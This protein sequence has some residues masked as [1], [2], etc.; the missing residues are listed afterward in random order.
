MSTR[1]S[2]SGWWEWF[3][4]TPVWPDMDK[5]RKAFQID[6]ISLGFVI[7]NILYLVV[8]AIQNS[9]VVAEAFWPSA[10][11]FFGIALVIR[12]INHSG[13]VRA[14]SL[15]MLAIF[16][17][18]YN[19]SSLIT[20]GIFSADYAA[21]V[22]LVVVAGLLVSFR[23]AVLLALVSLGMGVYIVYASSH[24]A[25]SPRLATVTVESALA[26]YSVFFSLGIATL[27][28]ATRNLQAALVDARQSNRDLQA[29]RISLEDQ[30]TE[31]TR[32][33]E[34]ARQ[35][36]EVSR[37]EAE[38]ARQQ[39]EA[40]RAAVEAQAWRASGQVQLDEVLRGEQSPQ[41]L[42][43]NALRVLC[44]YLNLPSAL[45]YLADGEM[46]RRVGG[47]AIDAE[48]PDTFQLGEGLVGQAALDKRAILLDPVPA[49]VLR[50][51]SALGE[52]APSQVLI[53]PLLNGDALV[54]VLELA[55]LQ[56]LS[57]QERQFLQ[58]VEG[59]LAS[60]L[61]TAQARQRVNDLLMQTQRQAE[62]LQAQ[63]EELRA[64]NEELQAQAESVHGQMRA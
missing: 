6:V 44:T 33:A 39:A 61:L 49:S 43:A 2:R 12:L 50:I 18:M 30:V 1:G 58:Q 26:T 13:R 34:A 16:W 3:I 55:T 27:Y 54:G 23:G 38:V 32:R 46:L 35:E 10:A 29:I 11:G 8:T 51:R 28:V 52:S 7:G 36:A 63:E 21:N 20:G 59:T 17:I 56:P 37:R 53:Q 5:S 41:S 64:I 22:L 14:A 24:N 57:V 48:P 9:G 40:A 47:Y 4:R 25:L 31:R 42:A 60:A 45:L 15:F 19:G 62:E